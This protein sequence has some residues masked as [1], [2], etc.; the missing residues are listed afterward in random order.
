MVIDSAGRQPLEIYGSVINAALIKMLPANSSNN[1]AHWGFII[2]TWVFNF[3]F[4]ITGGPLSWV[5]PA[6]L[7]GTA[8]RLK[9]I[10][11]GAMTSFAFN[12]M[13]GQITPIAVTAIGWRWYI[14]FTFCNF[15][16]AI[17]FWEFLPKRKV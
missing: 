13:I 8:I 3:V 9:G 7:F 6:K 17:F 2:T 4:S 5:I 16:N 1:R 14:I 12:T 15:T 10:S 11:W